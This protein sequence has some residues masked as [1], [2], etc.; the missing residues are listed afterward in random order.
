M[1]KTPISYY[2]G[3]QN[4]VSTILPILQVPHA[5]YVE[6]FVGGG[7]VFWAKR[8]SA[9]ES[10]NDLDDR[11]INFY[12]VC[13][14]RFDELN[15]RVQSTLHS[16]SV[17]R[18]AGK[19]LKEAKADEVAFAWAFWV[20][21]NMS[22]GHKLFAGFRFAQDHDEAQTT[23]NSKQKFTTLLSER[24]ASV[25][26]FSRDALSVIALKDAKDTL[27]YLDP[28]YVSSDCG[29]Y[30]GYTRANWEELLHTLTTIKGKF[31]LS[32]YPEPELAELLAGQ[33]WHQH[34]IQQAIGVTGKKAGKVKTEVITSNFLPVTKRQQSLFA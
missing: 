14:A 19:I 31:V 20:Q 7:A 26:I 34:Q 17:Y 27:F 30:K 29:H 13:Q 33:V 18:L 5:R 15:D 11:V 12:R 6:A 24:L 28:P 25:E 1:A 22:F 10:I 23:H 2:G 9:L 16:E 3:K 4:L 21:T 32:S 8:P